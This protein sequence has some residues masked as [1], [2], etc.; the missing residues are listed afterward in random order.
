[1]TEG[2]HRWPW[3]TIAAAAIV[4]VTAALRLAWPS[5]F[6]WDGD[7]A[8]HFVRAAELARGERLDVLVGYRTSAGGAHLPALF[9][10]VLAVPCLVGAGP[11]GV[12][13]WI[14]AADVV[15][16][17]LLVTAGR[18]ALGDGTALGAG[19]L[20]AVLPA[21]V[22]R[23]RSI[24]NETLLVPLLV[25]LLLLILEAR[26]RGPSRA[27]GLGLATALIMPQLHLSALFVLPGALLALAAPLWRS[28]WRRAAPGLALLAVVTLPFFVHETRTGFSETRALLRGA[29]G[30]DA[31]GKPMGSIHASGAQRAT[32]GLASLE[33]L[34]STDDAARYWGPTVQRAAVGALAAPLRLGLHAAA[35]VVPLLALVGLGLALAGRLGG[36]QRVV[37]GL[38]V[39]TLAAF[40]AG[41]VVALPPYVVT[42]LPAVCLLVAGTVAAAWRSTRALPPALTRRAAR[43]ALVAASTLG[44]LSFGAFGLAGVAALAREGGAHDRHLRATYAPKRAAVDWILEHERA[45]SAYPNAQYLLTLDLAWRALPDER[46]GRFGVLQQALPY[47]DVP[48]VVPVPRG[49]L[50]TV[51]IVEAAPSEELAGRVL[52]RFGSVAVVEGP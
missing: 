13:A 23:A 39:G 5:H 34:L 43:T 38:T 15:A 32:A 47:W 7:F 25:V 21:A 31:P 30:A 14:A 37:A 26:R 45:L 4:L 44:L 40:L 27:A 22:T 11:I 10:H 41:G 12:T 8:M 36:E 2:D 1:M 50:R 28:G 20:L 16:V 35:W 46:R 18:R 52:A 48:Y 6:D 19:A 51:S 17:L 49:A 24:R 3:P 42:L 29:A 33:D 9:H